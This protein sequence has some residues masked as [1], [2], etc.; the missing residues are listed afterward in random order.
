MS[1]VRFTV[2]GGEF[3]RVLEAVALFQS[4]PKQF[5]P[6]AG[7]RC[8]LRYDGL[9]MLAVNGVSAAVGTVSVASVDGVGLFSFPHSQVKALLAVFKRALPKGADQDEYMLE[10]RVSED[11]IRVED[12]S[13]LFDRDQ[14]TIAIPS[15]K[16]VEPHEQTDEQRV[17]QTASAL[18]GIVEQSTPLDLA[19]GVFFD[20][21]EL[22]R[23]ARAAKVVGVEL[24]LRAVGRGVLAPLS[25]EVVAYTVASVRQVEEHQ[26]P[27][28]IDERAVRQ[29]RQRLAE[30]VDEGVLA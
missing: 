7:V 10:V 21:A 5:G 9:T 23:I 27:P 17:M 13:H 12:I 24:C 20:P 1:D 19:S 29:Y 8:V 6:L 26:R 25:D 30:I 16:D 2:V 22:A 18:L 11:S 3:C 4:T 28:F 15:A 14:L